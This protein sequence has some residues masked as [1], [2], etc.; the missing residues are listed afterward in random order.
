MPRPLGHGRAKNIVGYQTKSLQAGSTMTGATFLPVAGNGVD[1]QS[2]FP[3]GDNIDAGDVNIQTLDA[4]GRT[5]NM[6]TYYG[7]GE[8]D[9]GAA[10][11]WYTDDGLAI[12]SFA[13]GQGLWV[14]APDGDT[15]I[16]YSGTVGKA[17]VTVELLQGGSTAT[18]NM[19][20]V[21]IFIQD[22]IPAGDN[23]DFGDVN[24]QTLD[25]FGR[26]E[27]MYTYYGEGEFDDGAAAG[28][29]TDDGLANVSFEPGQ[30]LWVASPDAPTS[31]QFPAPEL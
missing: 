23:I 16:T 2:I 13:P 7:E 8:F 25:A 29:Y 1:I 9:D 24:I 10:A 28:W 19:M 22:I 3:T 18:A 20:P 14:A 12:V 17:D 30:G 4:F 15:T 6:Y 11:G 21:A 27:N 5:E 26:T 31:L